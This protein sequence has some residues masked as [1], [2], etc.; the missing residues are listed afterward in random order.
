MADK[1]YANIREIL[2]DVIGARLIEVTHH[3]KEEFNE[4]GLSYVALHFD[5][6]LSLAF[7]TDADDDQ[8]FLEIED[9][10]NTD[11]D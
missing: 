7:Y 5:N 10:A 9:A 6:G 11:G 3:D 8:K 2:G 4:T 1:P